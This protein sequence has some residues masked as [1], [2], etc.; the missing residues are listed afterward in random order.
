MERVGSKHQGTVTCVPSGIVF[1]VV[2]ISQS[3]VTDLVVDFKHSDIGPTHAAVKNG[4]LMDFA[5]SELP[6]PPHLPLHPY[7]LA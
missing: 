7:H 3:F 4:Y 2:Q 6:N 1:L 5:S